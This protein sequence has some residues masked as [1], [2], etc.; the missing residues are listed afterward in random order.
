MIIRMQ[1][2]FKQ[3]HYKARAYDPYIG[4]FLQTDPIGYGDGM[5]SQAYVGGD[6]VNFTDPTG[7]S[8]FERACRAWETSTSDGIIRRGVSCWPI[9]HSWGPEPATNPNPSEPGIDV[10]EPTSPNGKCLKQGEISMDGDVRASPTDIKFLFTDPGLSLSCYGGCFKDVSG[11]S[12]A[13]GVAL[14]GAGQPLIDTRGKLGGATKGISFASRF[15]RKVFGKTR[16]MFRVLCSAKAMQLTMI[17]KG[18]E[19][20]HFVADYAEIPASSLS[21]ETDLEKD[22][23]WKASFPDETIEW[24]LEDIVDTFIIVYKIPHEKRLPN[25]FKYLPVWL[26]NIIEPIFFPLIDFENIK[27]ADMQRMYDGD[28]WGMGPARK[29]EPKT[30]AK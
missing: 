7:L 30:S 25:W 16:S 12:T 17:K 11:L 15:F 23:D 10:E 26:S 5:N 4:R 19:A 21:L 22:I 20:I 24:L 6:P 14:V 2:V 9:P 28:Y 29:P 18:E 8:A 1:I 3:H 27:I 13:G